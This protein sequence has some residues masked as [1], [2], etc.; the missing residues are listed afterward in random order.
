[1]LTKIRNRV[2]KIRV[3]VGGVRREDGQGMVEYGVILLV[4]LLTAVAVFGTISTSQKGAGTTV[5]T[6]ITN[7]F[8]NP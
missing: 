5:G 3:Y 8:T 1:M 7:S 2:R 6:Q 4:V